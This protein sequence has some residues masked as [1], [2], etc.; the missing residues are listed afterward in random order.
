MVAGAITCSVP[1]TGVVV[2]IALKMVISAS[3]SLFLQR[4][5]ISRGNPGMELDTIL[6]LIKV[7]RQYIVIIGVAV[8][9]CRQKHILQL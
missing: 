6:V 5:Q 9:S 3:R 7:Y 8:Q 2:A 4:I 1:V